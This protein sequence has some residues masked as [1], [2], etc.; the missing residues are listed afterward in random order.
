MT[1]RV[2][3][4]AQ[5]QFLVPCDLEIIICS[6]G[7]YNSIPSSIYGPLYCLAYQNG[8]ISKQFG[9]TPTSALQ[10]VQKFFFKLHL[11][12][13]PVLHF[14]EFIDIQ[15]I[16]V[17]TYIQ[18]RLKDIWGPHLQWRSS[19]HFPRKDSKTLICAQSVSSPLSEVNRSYASWGSWHRPVVCQVLC[20]CGVQS[21][22]FSPWHWWV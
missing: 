2:F 18:E 14:L 12:W 9:Q 6:K 8:Y 19:L 10:P 4:E 15:G 16:Y 7:L 22:C 3:W 5:I 1:T 11:V 17:P 21:C 20:T 13:S